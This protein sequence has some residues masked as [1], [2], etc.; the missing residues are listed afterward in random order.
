MTKLYL[1]LDT[2]AYTT[3]AAIADQNGIRA[4]QTQILRVPEG[5]KG[6][7]QS[8]AL[9]QHV[10]NLPQVFAALEKNLGSPFAQTLA[11]IAVSVRPRPQEL[12]YMPVF[13]AGQSAAGILAAATGAPVLE[14]SHQENHIEAIL[15]QTKEH[16]QGA[17]LAVHFSGGTSELVLA[18]R[19]E[20]GYHCTMLAESLDLKAGQLIDRTGVALGLSF[21]AGPALETL[22]E[23]ALGSLTIP[24][25]LEGADFHFSGQENIVSD[26]LKAGEA[27]EEIADAVLRM[28]ARTLERAIRVLIKEHPIKTVVFSGG[29]MSNGIIRRTL[30][31][32]LEKTGLRLIFAAPALARDSA[33]GNAL[34]AA[35]VLSGSD[36]QAPVF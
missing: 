9:Y 1:G 30:T 24:T 32:R 36:A 5:A 3:S 21:P 15:S 33:V 2:S 19:S 26:L 14:L 11:G 10:K 20:T 31:K 4:S 16:P 13:R 12:S 34:L 28:I 17:F 35:R 18:Q 25:R 8:E 29:V 27:P 22:A 6:L 7:R 23:T